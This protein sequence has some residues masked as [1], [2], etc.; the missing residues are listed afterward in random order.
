VE[1]LASGKLTIKPVGLVGQSIGFSW[2]NKQRF[3]LI[4]DPV[5]CRAALTT[6]SGSASHDPIQ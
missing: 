4:Q 5:W 6:V 2:N 1:V 3:S